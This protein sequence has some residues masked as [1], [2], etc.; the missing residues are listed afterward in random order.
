M[1]GVSLLSLIFFACF[2]AARAQSG[3][4]YQITQSVIPG[5]GGVSTNGMQRLEGTIG[6]AIPGSSSG[7]DYTLDGGFVPT[8]PPPL[9]NLGGRITLTDGGALLGGVTVN[10]SGASSAAVLT[11]AGGFYLFTDL[12]PDSYTLTPMRTHFSFAPAHHPITLSSANVMDADFTATSTASNPQPA[13]GSVLISEFRLSSTTSDDEFIE[14]YNNTDSAID[15]SGYQLD[16]LAGFTITIPASTM[17]PARAHY[18]IAHQTGYTLAAYATP[19][20]TYSGFDLPADTGLAL[21]NT[22]NV[23]VDAVG[24]SAT[25][26]P[27]REGNGLAPIN[28]LAQY[29]F[30]RQTIT[31]AGLPNTGRPQDT[32]DNAAD[33]LLVATDPNSITSATAMLGAPAPENLSSPIQ[34]DAQVRATLV[35]PLQSP[36]GANNRARSSTANQAICGGNCPLGTLSIRRTYTNN[37]GQPIT[38]LRFRIVDITTT[39]EG[40]NNNGTADLRAVSRSGSLSMTRS[41]GSSVMVQGLSLEQPPNQPSGGGVNA[42]LVA[43]TITLATPLAATDDPATA[44]KEN[45]INVEFLVGV[46]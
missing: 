25:A 46:M 12:A 1:R 23:I 3:G 42:S 30:V 13:G 22:A 45:A 36:A 8:A 29:S 18:L 7:G 11:D 4:S 31:G 28:G 41:D 2:A 33:F 21:F 14:L 32:G 37:T 27:Y 40:S 35:D 20:L 38:R 24:F 44:G 10:L 39:P 34:R 26:L 16:A 5:G 6:Q 9:L 43:P 15:L 17:L 19:N